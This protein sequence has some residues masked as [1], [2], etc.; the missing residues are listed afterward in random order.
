MITGDQLMLHAIGDYITQ[1]DWMANEKTKRWFPAACHATLYSLPFLALS[2]SP[3]AFA[4]I[5]GTHYLIDRYRVARY[6]VWAK[7]WLSP[8]VWWRKEMGG[9][10]T[11]ASIDTAENWQR[12]I[13]V[14][15]TVGWTPEAMTNFP[16]DLK[17]IVTMV[18]RANLP[19]SV[20]SVT[21]YPPERP[22]WLAF[23]L[24]II[25]DNIL[26]VCINGAALRWL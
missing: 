8:P 19:F 5:I 20:C 25:A 21:G 13:G 16:D 1:S 15:R 26:H 17:A 12:M 22:A 4:V 9:Y 18:H 23:W 6:V 11:S 7:N 10:W 14:Q 3:A 24:L 2:P